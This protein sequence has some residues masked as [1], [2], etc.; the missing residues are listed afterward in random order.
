MEFCRPAQLVIT[1]SQPPRGVSRP[2][3]WSLGARSFEFML[4]S[5][6]MILF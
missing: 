5:R 3:S 6:R 2:P 4:R 1:L